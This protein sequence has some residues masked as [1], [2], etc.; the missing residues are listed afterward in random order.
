MKDPGSTEFKNEHVSP[1]GTYCAEVNSKN[2]YGAYVGFERVMAKVDVFE[3]KSDGYVL[4]ER[5][6]VKGDGI[7]GT[8]VQL[9]L[10]TATTWAKINARRELAAGDKDT[11]SEQEYQEI[12]LHKVFEEEW[13]EKCSQELGAK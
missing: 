12:A 11:L 10:Q 5:D 8:I 2:S 4:F 6:G 9:E 3:G 1:G 7:G 13:S